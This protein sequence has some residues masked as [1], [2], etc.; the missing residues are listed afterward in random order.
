MK[1]KFTVTYPDGSKP[2]AVPQRA[3]HVQEAIAT[4]KDHPVIKQEKVT[5]LP[6]YGIRIKDEG[7]GLV[8]V[9]SCLPATNPHT[10]IKPE[11]GVDDPNEK[12]YR[13]KGNIEA[14]EELIKYHYKAGMKV[15]SKAYL[16]GIEEFVDYIK[17]Y[18]G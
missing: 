3:A 15:T 16:K 12:W 2:T 8:T 17:K 4:S 11:V 1:N 10:Y 18:G 9:T 5:T 13:Y 14:L 7:Q 6:L